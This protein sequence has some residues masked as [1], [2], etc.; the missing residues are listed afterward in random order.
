M[1]AQTI[2]AQI[3]DAHDAR[4]PEGTGCGCLDALDELVADRLPKDT[5]GAALVPGVVYRFVRDDHPTGAKYPTFA[6]YRDAVVEDDDS[7][8]LVIEDAAG[9]RRGVSGTFYA[10]ERLDVVYRETLPE[11]TLARA[12][13]GDR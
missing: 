6:I 9:V 8:T 7:V 13:D 10:V 5:T 12:H 2:A 3:I 1:N 11:P 4:H